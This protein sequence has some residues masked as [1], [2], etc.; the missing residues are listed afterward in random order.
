MAYTTK[1][2]FAYEIITIV[3]WYLTINIDTI[4]LRYIFHNDEAR[5]FFLYI[6]FD[7]FSHVQIMPNWIFFSLWFHF[8]FEYFAATNLIAMN[9]VLNITNDSTI[10]SVYDF[11]CTFNLCEVFFLFNLDFWNFHPLSL[12]SFFFCLLL[13]NNENEIYSVAMDGWRLEKKG[14]MKSV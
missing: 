7:R 12:D 6:L 11:I 4:S 5:F 9:C 2:V 8:R 1:Y 13:W 3:L 10:F 14:L